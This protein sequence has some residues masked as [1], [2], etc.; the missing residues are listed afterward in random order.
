MRG[1]TNEDCE[2]T[3]TERL[4]LEGLRLLMRAHLY[5]GGRETITSRHIDDEMLDWLKAPELQRLVEEKEA[6]AWSG[7]Q[8]RRRKSL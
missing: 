8:D 6:A 1:D 5:P 7:E 3:D 4:M 2:M